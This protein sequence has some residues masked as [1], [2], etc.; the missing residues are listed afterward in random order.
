MPLRALLAFAI[1]LV[2]CQGGPA[3]VPVSE[4]PPPE[5]EIIP[6]PSFRVIGHRGAAGHAPENTL[7]SFEAA[8]RLGVEEV[9]LDVQISRDGVPML[10]HDG[11]L[12]GKTRLEGRVADH[13][14][15]TLER[16]E[17]GSWFASS[18]P[19]IS[20][21]FDSA[22][23]VS[24][25]QLLDRFGDSFHYHVELKTESRQAPRL[26]LE[27]LERHQ[28]RRR[29]TISSFHAEPLGVVRRLDPEI[30]ISLLVEDV[31]DLG[32]AAQVEEA[33]AGLFGSGLQERRIQQAVN[34]NFQMVA[35]PARDLSRELVDYAHS[36]GLEIRA[37]G[38]RGPADLDH[39]LEVGADGATLDHP[40]WALARRGER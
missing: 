16:A 25:D 1:M 36:R 32:R 20:E 4:T 3:P 33:L 7:P 27:A 19:E 26:V 6:L 8:K 14:A 22:T 34:S 11:S 37:W 23:I 28:L 39:T 12:E 15:A 29:A 9:E 30:P 18:H 2:A 21:R 17:L 31:D 13:D 10:F 40:E 24:L 5:S 35:F 38:V